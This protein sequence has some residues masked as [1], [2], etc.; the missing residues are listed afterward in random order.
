[1]SVSADILKAYGAPRRVMR[2]QLAQSGE[3]RAFAYLMAAVFLFFLAR[4]PA[5]SREVFLNGGEP[6]FAALASGTFLGAV[7]IAPLVFYGLAALSHMIARLLGGRG[8]WLS[9]RL[10]LFWSLLTVSPLVLLQGLVAGFIGPGVEL[11]ITSY[12]V[13]LTFAAFWI[14]NLREAETPTAVA[15][16]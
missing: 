10:A 12:A 5:L 15:A 1:M 13:G 9:A 7:L 11:S 14:I 4:L 8:S 16:N 3:D 6:G 2:R